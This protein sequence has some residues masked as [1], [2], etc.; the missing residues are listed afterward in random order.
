ML[1]SFAIITINSAYIFSSPAGDKWNNRIN[2]SILIESRLAGERI[3]L[4]LLPGDDDALAHRLAV[5][6]NTRV[7]AP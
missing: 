7:A 5:R 6:N 4:H 1:Q 2:Y 3:L